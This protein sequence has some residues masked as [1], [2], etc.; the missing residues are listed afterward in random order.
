[1][2]E[3]SNEIVVD[4]SDGDITENKYMYTY[5]QLKQM[6]M[7]K[8]QEDD[9][10]RCLYMIQC[11]LIYSGLIDGYDELYYA[12]IYDDNKIVEFIN[13]YEEVCWDL[14]IANYD[15]KADFINN[16]FC[17]LRASE[18]RELYLEKLFTD[19]YEEILYGLFFICNKK[20]D[21]TEFTRDLLELIEEQ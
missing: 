10:L 2:S 1:M 11:H 20:D 4:F 16:G 15:T 12:D 18:L 19:D 7:N 3:Y 21:I 5:E 17:T 8:L 14:L 9:Y 13:E 6:L